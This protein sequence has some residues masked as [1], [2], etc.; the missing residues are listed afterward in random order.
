MHRCWH[1]MQVYGAIHP[2]SHLSDNFAHLGEGCIIAFPRTAL[3]GEEFISVGAGTMIAPWSTLSAGYGPGV[4]GDH[5]VELNIGRRC[6]I[7]LRSG[8]VAH[9]RITIGDDVFFGQD[10]FVTDSNHGYESLDTPIGRQFGSTSPIEVGDQSWIGHGAVLLAG[11]RVG[12]HAIVAAGAVVRDE[13]PDFT[14]AAGVP[15][16]VVSRTDGAG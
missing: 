5:A 10:V 3:F 15:A 14:I 1:T 8:L 11:A 4:P 6:T 12:R 7:G 13:V 16:R 2:G 9:E